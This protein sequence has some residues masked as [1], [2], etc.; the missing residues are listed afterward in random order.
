MLGA[1]IRRIIVRRQQQRHEYNG[2]SVSPDMKF[3]PG[4]AE[5][6]LLWMYL[7]FSVHRVRRRLQQNAVQ[8]QAL[9][10]NKD[11]FLV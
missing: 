5:P 8:R 2:G 11:I 10:I 4:N 3:I 1:W 7:S 6:Q 9:R